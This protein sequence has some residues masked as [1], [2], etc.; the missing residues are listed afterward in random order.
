MNPTISHVHL[1]VIKLYPFKL[2]PLSF[3]SKSKVLA[4]YCSSLHNIRF[5]EEDANLLERRR[6]FQ[7]MKTHTKKKRKIKKAKKIK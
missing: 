1:N 6:R 2:I 4:K 5:A 7:R 3:R